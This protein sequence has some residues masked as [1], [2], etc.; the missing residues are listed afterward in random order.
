MW[1]RR[2]P[3]RG[4]SVVITGGG[5][6]LGRAMALLA[7]ERGA[8]V[9]VWD[10]DGEA[11]AST[12]AQIEARG[13]RGRSLA[14]DV[15]DRGAVNDAARETGRV[16]VLINNAGIVT[17]GTF[18]EHSPADVERTFAVNT[19]APYWTTRAVLPQMLERDRGVIVTI[20]SAAALAGVAGQSAYSAS[21]HA[22]AGFTESLRAEL[23]ASGSGVRTLLVCPFFI[24]TGMF[25]GVQTRFP[26]L[27]PILREG[28]VAEGVLRA[29]ERG[30]VQ[31]L[32][33][34]LA[35]FVPAL[36]ILPPRVFDRV[37]DFFG[38]NASMSTFRGRGA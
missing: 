9:T 13:G 6:G 11:A 18:L 24:D 37:M 25:E 17:G 33:P 4:A 2:I 19:L 20:A 29:I 15:T 14:V 26:R 3:L 8:P 32:T 16:D 10:L 12:A 36:R 23:R 27:L 30:D 7:A 22:A 5:R 34:P 35:R 28:E 38:T 1:G 31:Y 21:K